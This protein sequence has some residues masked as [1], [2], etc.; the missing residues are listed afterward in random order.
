MEPLAI[1]GIVLGGSAVLLLLNRY[2]NG[3]KNIYT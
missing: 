1:G 3:G 2:F